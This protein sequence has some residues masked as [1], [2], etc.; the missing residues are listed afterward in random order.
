MTPTTLTSPLNAIMPRNAQVT[1]AAAALGR[2]AAA[3]AAPT[4]ALLWLGAT[5]MV[6]SGVWTPPIPSALAGAGPRPAPPPEVSTV[7]DVG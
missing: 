5:L 1:E 3:V 6:L 7:T 2:R 4:L